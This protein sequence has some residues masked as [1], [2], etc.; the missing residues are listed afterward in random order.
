MTH[1]K[2]TEA[3]EF[4]PSEKL[5]EKNSIRRTVFAGVC[6]ANGWKPGKQLTEAEFLAAV[7][8]VTGAPMRGAAH[9]KEAKK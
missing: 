4:H 5:R 2:N 6:A 1:R 3:P 9:I 8:K 7:A